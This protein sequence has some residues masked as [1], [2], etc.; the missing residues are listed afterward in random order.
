MHMK[1]LKRFKQNYMRPRVLSQ[2]YKI[3]PVQ[4]CRIECGLRAYIEI[5]VFS[6]LDYS[7][8]L[9]YFLHSFS[10]GSTRAIFKPAATFFI[11]L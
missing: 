2:T 9:K 4:R 6:P 1:W 3:R 7:K 8:N 11:I 5:L 10:L